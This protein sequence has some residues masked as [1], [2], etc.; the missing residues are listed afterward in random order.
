MTN[1]KNKQKIKKGDLVAVYHGGIGVAVRANEDIIEY[2]GPDGKLRKDWIELA[3]KCV[4]FIEE[5]HYREAF[6]NRTWENESPEFRKNMEKNDLESEKRTYVVT[7][8]DHLCSISNVTIE[9]VKKAGEKH[10]VKMNKVIMN[11]R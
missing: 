8:N 10:G 7:V 6:G 9:Q 2:A 1:D 11:K 3:D 5:G 4:K